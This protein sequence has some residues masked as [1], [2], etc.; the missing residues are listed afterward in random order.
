[1]AEDFNA[2][3]SFRTSGID[4]GHFFQF[5]S[6]RRGTQRRFSIRLSFPKGSKGRVSPDGNIY[7][8][9]RRTS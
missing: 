1:M 6:E 2:I 9:Q 8:F 3:R 4:F 5:T 7:K